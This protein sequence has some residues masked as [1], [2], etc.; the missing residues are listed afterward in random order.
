MKTR[1]PHPRKTDGN[2]LRCFARDSVFGLK[3]ELAAIGRDPGLPTPLADLGLTNLAPQRRGPVA[4]TTAPAGPA[5]MLKPRASGGFDEGS[6][7]RLALDLV[8]S[9]SSRGQS[10]SCVGGLTG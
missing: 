3:P 4:S 7:G 2:P 6:V 10:S 9:C 1:N 5:C 8:R